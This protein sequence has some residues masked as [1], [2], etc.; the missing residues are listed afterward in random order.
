MGS[1]GEPDLVEQDDS[2]A[3]GLHLLDG[4]VEHVDGNLIRLATDVNSCADCSKVDP[5]I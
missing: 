5:P 3:E 1:F 4:L 2:V